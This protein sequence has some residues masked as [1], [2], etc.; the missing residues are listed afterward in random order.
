[1]VPRLD[2]DVARCA[3]RTLSFPSLPHLAVALLALLTVIGS[4]VPTFAEGPAGGPLQIKKASPEACAMLDNAPTRARM[5][6]LL[7]KLLLS[8]GRADELGY[9]VQSP[10]I[11]TSTEG[12]AS[13]LAD[14]L[15]N[16][17]VGDDGTNSH[18]QS[19]SSLAYSE[20]T[21]TICSGYNDS[22]H[23]VVQNQGFTG[24]S[25]STDGGATFDDRG[26]LGA[27]SFGDP[28]LIW[29]RSDQN[30]YIAA[31]ESNGLGIWRSTDDCESFTFVGNTHVGGSD[32]KEILAIDNTMAS[33]FFGRMYVGWT[34]FTDSR[35]YVN[36]SSDNGVT[37][38]TPVAV[39]AVG[40]DV[41]GAWPVVAP[42]GDVFVGWVR[43]N[44]F[45][46]GP[47]DIEIVRSTDGGDTFAAVTNPATGEVNPRDNAAS[48]ACFRPAL[49][50]NIR[51]LPSPQ[52]V[53]G[54]DGV[55][56]VVYSYD[57][58]GFDV[59]DEV[60]VFY[61]RS[62][63]SGAT[64][65]PEI[66]LN[67]D[68]TTTDQFFPTL[69]IGESNTVISTWYDRRNDPNNI[70]FDY[71]QRTSFDGGANWQPSIRLSDV[72][73]PVFLDPNLAGCYHGDYDMQ[74]QTAE[75]N[76]VQWSDDRNIQDGHNDPDIWFEPVAIGTDFLVT[77]TPSSV[78]V[79]SPD[80]AVSQ[81]DVLQFEG[82]VEPVTLTTPAIPGGLTAG[83]STNPVVPPGVSTLTVMTGAAAAG[84]YDVE[85]VG[86]SAPSAIVHDTTFRID[87]FD[88]VPAAPVQ[89]TPADTATGV[90]LVPVLGWDA[91]TQAV[92]YFVEIATD[93][94]F[95]NV[96]YSATE[97]GTTHQVTTALDPVTTYHW[98]VRGENV[99]GQGT[100][101]A[102]FSFT[103]RDIPPILVVDDDDN[104]PDIQAFV[105]DALDALGLAYDV[106]DTGNSDNEPSDL[107]LAPYS[108]V[109]WV[110]GDEFGGA[111][112]PGGAGETALGNWLDT[113]NKCLFLSSQD[114][115]FDRGLTT[116]MMDRLGLTAVTDD[117][118]HA[119]ATGSAGGVFDGLGPYTLTYPGSNFSDTLT[120]D[121][122]A[123]AAFDGDQGL[124]GVSKDGGTYKT[125]F[126][127]FPY[128]AVPT[129]VDRQAVL[130]AF[131]NFCGGS[132]GIF[133]DGFESGDT[134][135][136]SLTGQ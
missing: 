47:I 110:T 55:L 93:A 53:V 95:S 113:G 123:V 115:H 92:S 44:P 86:T 38:S 79:C 59:G 120:A 126:L 49:D 74:I 1:M 66:Q 78:A 82:F 50:G 27:N 12:G 64:W 111:A 40:A 132:A 34:D 51:Y 118:N 6:G 14:V 80:D 57:Q 26:P 30:F 17:P 108:I 4:A 32:D 121:G 16:D 71:Y 20:T 42:N 129:D 29:S 36:Y 102:G 125:V 91:A 112:G 105:T 2:H 97:T 75:F 99:C 46:D 87:L 72:S 84:S 116:F 100:F 35:I 69:S 76:L 101:S 43:W 23:G 60:D 122:T 45:P 41:Q 67:D 130:D 21:G 83:F 127:G 96:I 106:W 81:I 136:W 8:C 54:P 19:E 13:G 52:L 11:D 98:R 37:W 25:R 5:D 133:E 39:S 85:V 62:L 89:T 134:S 68:G 28:S 65:E 9:V 18:T 24:I 104:T 90:D 48:G 56:H 107:E 3:R 70:L 114:Y 7:Y 128:E 119:T 22:F 15:V 94:G 33:P 31:L 124:A 117:T 63:D 58:D 109:L 131:F 88:Q 77:A 135:A 61:R 73:S 10:A 103:T